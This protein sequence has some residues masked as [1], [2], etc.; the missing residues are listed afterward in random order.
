MKVTLARSTT[1]S[2]SVESITASR[3]SPRCAALT[4][5]SS[6]WCKA[7]L[8][9]SLREP[10]FDRPPP[11]LS[12]YPQAEQSAAPGPARRYDEYR[13][14]RSPD[15]LAGGAVPVPP[16]VRPSPARRNED[17][18][19]QLGAELLD[20]HVGFVAG[21]HHPRRLDVYISEQLDEV[22]DVLGR[23]LAGNG[24]SRLRRDH[25][26]HPGVGRAELAAQRATAGRP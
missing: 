22:A 9:V 16:P 5:S 7:H 13:T 6:P 24:A 8:Q 1:T 12:G 25:F 18:V 10:A 14:R 15:Q 2:P 19:A 11:D 21:Q 17:G 4:R 26:G 3:R 23:F 20:A